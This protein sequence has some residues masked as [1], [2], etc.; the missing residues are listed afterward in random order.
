MGLAPAFTVSATHPRDIYFTE[1]PPGPIRLFATLEGFGQWSNGNQFSLPAQV[2]DDQ[3][4]LAYSPADLDD[5]ADIVHAAELWGRSTVKL[6]VRVRYVPPDHQML[7]VFEVNRLWTSDQIPAQ[8]GVQIFIGSKWVKTEP[9]DNDTETFALLIDA[10]DITVTS[11]E[12][13]A[14]YPEFFDYVLYLRLAGT[15]AYN[16]IGFRGVNGYFI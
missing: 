7:L 6:W 3:L 1:G 15:P 5:E 9:I 13:E 2:A 11:N 4:V 16:G 10:P 8:V 14:F 12:N